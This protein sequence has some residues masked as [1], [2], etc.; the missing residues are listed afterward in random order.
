MVEIQTRRARPGFFRITSEL[1]NRQTEILECAARGLTSSE[2]GKELFVATQTVKFHR[3]AIIK[4]LCA[5][6][7]TQAVAVGYERGILKAK[8]LPT[9]VIINGVLFLPG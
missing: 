2:T 9:E 5:K 1:T 7:I 6:N 3:T 4:K 8:N